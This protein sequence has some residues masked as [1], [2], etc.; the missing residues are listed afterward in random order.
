MKEGPPTA[1]M[2]RNI[3]LRRSFS[4][5]RLTLYARC[6]F[7]QHDIQDIL[8][9]ADNFLAKTFLSMPASED[10]RNC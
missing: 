1:P 10:E 6:C 2:L 7:G 5:L 3:D 4:R 8:A 9:S